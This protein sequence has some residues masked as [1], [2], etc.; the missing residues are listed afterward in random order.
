MKRFAAALL[1]IMNVV[2]TLTAQ[3]NTFKMIFSG[4]SYDEGV[5]AFRTSS[6]GYLIVGNTSSYGHGGSDVW[7]I[8]LDSNANFQ[9]QKT[10]GGQGDEQAVKAV[11]TKN[12]EIIITGKTT[13]YNN[14]VNFFILHLTAT[15]VPLL[16]KNYGGSDWDFAESAAVFNDSIYLICGKTFNGPDAGYYNAFLTAISQNG[17]TLF[18]KY[19]G[20]N[21]QQEYTDIKIRPDNKIIVCGNYL[22]TSQESDSGFVRCMDSAGNILWNSVVHTNTRNG[23]ISLAASSDSGAIAVGYH[24][25]PGETFRRPLSVRF[26]KTGG[27]KWIHPETTNADSYFSSIDT[28]G[29]QWL[30]I[31]G[32]TTEFSYHGDK[33]MYL[34]RFTSGGWFNKTR[35]CSG[36]KDETIKSFSFY[37]FDSTYLGIGPTKS[38]NAP[39]SGI[40]VVQTNWDIRFDTTTNL[41]IVSGFSNNHKPIN[42]KIY[43]TPVTDILTIE[44]ENNKG[45]KTEI[46]IRDLSGKA[47]LRRSLT[48]NGVHKL[49]LSGLATG[50]YVAEIL[51]PDNRIPVKIVK[52]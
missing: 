38:F 15:G 51:T 42:I 25:D 6:K 1:L 52:R 39:M 19:S 11:I 35:L 4:P 28:I 8:A 13:S 45:G 50:V 21:P 33:D 17:D 18:T 36:E 5:A 31:G 46:I 12:D 22:N 49:N 26:T 20:A 30:T 9:W 47:V 32:M 29:N 41:I 40:L 14:T 10:Y 48:G 16:L 43:P 3:Q 27:L 37:G 2:V 44:T 7:V 34:A 23:L 24:Y